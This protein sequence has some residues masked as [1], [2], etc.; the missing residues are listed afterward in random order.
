MEL[1]DK[2][3]EK[4]K[5][6]KKRA[7]DLDISD[8]EIDKIKN[9]WLGTKTKCAFC[10]DTSKRN[11][12]VEYQ[13]KNCKIDSFICNIGDACIVGKFSSAIDKFSY[14]FGLHYE[15]SVVL[16]RLWSTVM[17]NALKYA[18]EGKEITALDVICFIST[19][20]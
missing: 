18:K 10:V 16:L 7:E 15:E 11:P 8:P 9:I 20:I 1:Y 12:D 4:W 19:H 17:I 13:C 3:I 5:R 2:S 6:I 14:N